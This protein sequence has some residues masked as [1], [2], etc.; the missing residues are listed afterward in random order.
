[1]LKRVFLILFFFVI[2]FSFVGAEIN[3]CCPETLDGA[4]CQDVV[5]ASLCDVS[6]LKTSCE[7]SDSCREICC[8]DNEEGLCYPRSPAQFCVSRG[9]DESADATCSN[10]VRCSEGCCV[11]GAETEFVTQRRCEV[12]AEQEGV[13]VNVQLE[14]SKAMCLEEAELQKE[15]ACVHVVGGESVC[16][17][18][19]EAGCVRA[20]G[21]FNETI[22]CT[23]SDLE[24]GCEP[25]QITNC[26]EGEDEV[27]LLHVSDLVGDVVQGWDGLD[28]QLEL[29][30]VVYL[31]D[32][33]LGLL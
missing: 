14:F 4:F 16:V 33:E 11:L 12:R 5:D 6:L 29:Y 3:Y 28:V 19:S 22:L 32:I 13:G 24:G 25:T 31:G 2:V 10:D 27:W 20:E 30:A 15:G 9:G 1:M 26:F 8:F 18:T 21:N 7:R 17:F 23:S